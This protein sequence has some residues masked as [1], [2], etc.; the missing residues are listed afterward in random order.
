M[1]KE[2]CYQIHAA[3]IYAEMLAQVCHKGRYDGNPDPEGFQ[4]VKSRCNL[5]LPQSFVLHG[6]HAT[7]YMFMLSFRTRRVS[8]RGTLE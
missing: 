3:Q 2:A 8:R 7:F 6:R 5:Y 4:E 1:D